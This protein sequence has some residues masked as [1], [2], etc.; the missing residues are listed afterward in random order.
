MQV[1][2]EDFSLYW[3][4][5]SEVASLHDNKDRMLKRMNVEIE[6]GTN[7]YGNLI[8]RKLIEVW[9]ISY[10]IMESILHTLLR[11]IAWKTPVEN[12]PGAC[13]DRTS[14]IYNLDRCKDGSEEYLDQ[15]EQIAV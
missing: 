15:I 6:S 5:N 8:H 7:T 2:F 13:C 1:E 14:L 3:N 10:Q 12:F 4:C 9:I 11:Q